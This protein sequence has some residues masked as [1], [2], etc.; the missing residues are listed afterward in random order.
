MTDDEW[1]AWEGKAVKPE[2]Y[3]PSVATFEDW[4]LCPARARMPCCM[5]CC[6]FLCCCGLRLNRESLHSPDEWFMRMLRERHPNCPEEFAGIWWMKDNDAAEGLITLQDGSWENPRLMR[7][8]AKYNWTVDADNLWGA[9]LTAN[10]WVRGGNHEFSR[11]P[12]GKWVQISAI[13]VGASNFIYV[14]Q[15]GDVIKKPDGTILETT[16]GEDMI[17]VSYKTLDN[18]DTVTFQYLAR[19]V[20]YLDE[21]GKLVKTKYYSEIV[22]VARMSDRCCRG[23][24]AHHITSS[25]VLTFAP[26]L[27]SAAC[28]PAQQSM[29]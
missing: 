22:D 12:S 4:F 15:P 19:R 3:D 18:Q 7:K 29:A 24:V 6:R 17:R 23:R 1:A 26:P 20:A 25:Q 28:A 21:E 5:P 11:S 10:F 14:I 9:F 27:H 13:G 2:L 8:S 16:P